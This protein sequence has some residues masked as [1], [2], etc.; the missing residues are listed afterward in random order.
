MKN[1]IK[2][3]SFLTIIWLFTYWL[4][5]CGN[6][7]ITTKFETPQ[8]VDTL[9][10]QDADTRPQIT[11]ML[12]TKTEYDLPNSS[13][14]NLDKV[15]GFRKLQIGLDLREFQ[16]ADWPLRAWGIDE[17]FL[18]RGILIL[19]KR[20]PFNGKDI[21]IGKNN[22]LQ[23][24][25]LYFQDSILRKIV[26]EFPNPW[27]NVNDDDQIIKYLENM[28][29]QA[30]KFE[31]IKTEIIFPQASK[32]P[33]YNYDR[34]YKWKTSMIT[35]TLHMRNYDMEI[36]RYQE[37][38]YESTGYTEKLMKIEKIWH[39][40]LDNESKIKEDKENKNKLNEL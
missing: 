34:I 18:K 28:Y 22:V 35:L 10:K 25:T 7:T 29:G 21:R 30:T 17:F 12:A 36:Y 32:P 24:A 16:S 39:D 14:K 3:I 4:S 23:C 20:R 26:L 13:L 8:L 15:K 33:K 19:E 27:L 37:L 9:K 5:A 38:I 6:K 1:K 31:E 2:P 11:S 40:S